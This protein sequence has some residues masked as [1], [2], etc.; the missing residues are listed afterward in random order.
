MGVL[1]E[2]FHPQKRIKELIHLSMSKRFFKVGLLKDFCT[3]NVDRNDYLSRRGL[4][5]MMSPWCSHL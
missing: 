4:A 2:T 1:K 3:H 5:E